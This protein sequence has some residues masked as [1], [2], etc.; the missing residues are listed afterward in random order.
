MKK[1]EWII[2]DFLM[3]VHAIAEENEDNNNEEE[4]GEQKD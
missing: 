2:D 3:T 4:T 1:E